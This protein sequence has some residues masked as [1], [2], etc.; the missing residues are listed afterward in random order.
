L[1]INLM[2][3][4]PSAFDRSRR[5]ASCSSMSSAKVPG[6]ASSTKRVTISRKSAKVGRW[7]LAPAAAAL[8]ASVLAV[9]PGGGDSESV[10]PPG[11]SHDF[12]SDSD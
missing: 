1:V 7:A 4:S 11:V 9:T 10:V 3:A 6:G 5:R 2:T 8:A 12:D